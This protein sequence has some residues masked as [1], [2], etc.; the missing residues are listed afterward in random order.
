MISFKKSFMLLNTVNLLN[1]AETNCR[2]SK[3]SF[4][5]YQAG[6]TNEGEEHPASRLC[7]LAGFNQKENR[8]NDRTQ[9]ETCNSVNWSG[10][11]WGF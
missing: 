10:F 9:Q 2:D 7:C 1:H 4:I 3:P 8:P 5:G 11:L 6:R